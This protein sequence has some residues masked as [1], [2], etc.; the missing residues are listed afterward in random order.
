MTRQAS[1]LKPRHPRLSISVDRGTGVEFSAQAANAGKTLS[2]F[3]NEWLMA[4]SRISADGGTAAKS[5]DEWR[6]NSFFRDL[7]VVP[8]PAE[9]VEE[10]V[11]GLCKSDKDRAL[12]TFSALGA[13]LVSLMKIYAPDVDGLAN[14]A[15]AFAGIVPLKK[16]DLEKPDSSSVVL[17][18]VGAGRRFEVTECAFEFVKSILYGY[19][20]TVTGH[21]LGVGTIRVEAKRSGLPV[22]RGPASVPA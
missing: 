12:I 20:Y 8:L 3:A 17:N 6:V 10:L 14:L 5:L 15:R 21:E 13:E 7:E 18:V 11:E 16:L 2:A 4:A 22:E 9:F 1:E 19:G